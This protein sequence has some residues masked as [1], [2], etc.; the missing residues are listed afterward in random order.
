MEK[1]LL[2]EPVAHFLDR[3]TSINFNEYEKTNGERPSLGAI[4][5]GDDPSSA[6]YVGRKQEKAKK[7]VKGR[8]EKVPLFSLYKIFFR[9]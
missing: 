7:E 6:I 9:P 3:Q 5:I 1:L 4:T 8:K 2:G